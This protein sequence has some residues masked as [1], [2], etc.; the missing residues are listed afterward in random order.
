MYTILYVDD[1]P[2]LLAIGRIFLE[3]SKDF[4]VITL[5]SAE[6]ALQSTG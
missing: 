5:T 6:D 2:D 1:E 3:K 4:R